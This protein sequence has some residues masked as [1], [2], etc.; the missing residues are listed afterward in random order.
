MSL[1][2]GHWARRGGRKGGVGGNLEGDP[3]AG[4]GRVP[5][6]VSP[7]CCWPACLFALCC[8]S[9]PRPRPSGGVGEVGKAFSSA[10]CAFLQAG[11]PT[12]PPSGGTVA[13]RVV[14]A[15]C[16]WCAGTVRAF[17]PGA[18]VPCVLGRGGGMGSRSVLASACCCACRPTRFTLICPSCSYLGTHAFVAF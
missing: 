8:C 12:A 17:G 7:R 2:Q 4:G 6:R 11:R 13:A 14:T 9:R 5:F 1:K 18:D 15:L 10:C 16:R 3:G